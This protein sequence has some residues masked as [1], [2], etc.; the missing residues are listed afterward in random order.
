MKKK[1]D[2]IT[3]LLPYVTVTYFIILMA[4]LTFTS[5]NQ[6]HLRWFSKPLIVL[7]LVTGLILL[8]NTINKRYYIPWM[9]ALVFSWLGDVF[10]LL[11]ES[12]FIPGLVAFLCAHL[13]YLLVFYRI[14]PKA[15]IK[16]KSFLFTILLTIALFILFY[17]I[18]L[19]E[20]GN[21]FPAV[22]I[23]AL[24]ILAMW[25]L[26]SFKALRRYQ[27]NFWL[28]VGALLFVLS[29]S[30]LGYNKFVQFTPLISVL[31]MLT[32]GLAQYGLFRGILKVEK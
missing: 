1:S 24:V 22:L 11:D 28:W 15:S 9:I 32:Y 12:Y 23:Y 31:V 30:L 25:L 17:R 26:A 27:F 10:L 16:K 7:T 18:I 19:V 21:L 5:T 20:T 4:D 6:P 2:L 13:G 14:R 8:R 3:R 29:D